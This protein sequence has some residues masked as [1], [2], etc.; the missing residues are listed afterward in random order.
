MRRFL[1]LLLALTMMVGM[2]PANAF[3]QGKSQTHRG[4]LSN[5]AENGEVVRTEKGFVIRPKGF[6]PQRDAKR[7]Y[8]QDDLTKEYVKLDFAE[9]MEEFGT[10][11]S[12]AI[13]TMNAGIGIEYEKSYIF[14]EPPKDGEPPLPENVYPLREKVLLEVP[15]EEFIPIV[16]VQLKDDR[17]MQRALEFA[18]G[19]DTFEV[20]VGTVAHTGIE[21]RWF[22]DEK[23]IPANDLPAKFIAKNDVLTPFVIRNKNV[24]T[25]LRVGTGLQWRGHEVIDYQPVMTDA[26]MEATQF[27]I[28]HE[29]GLALDSNP[30]KGRVP[31]TVNQ[32]TTHKEG[33][34]QGQN[35]KTFLYKIIG[36]GLYGEN[37][38]FREKIN[39][40]FDS[41]G[42]TWKGEE[43]QPQV[44]G[45]S[46]K[47]GDKH[48]NSYDY[49][50]PELQSKLVYNDQWKD[51]PSIKNIVHS[52]D[53]AD[54][55]DP[56]LVEKHKPIYGEHSEVKKLVVPDKDD[57]TPPKAE[58]GQPEKEFKGWALTKDATEPLFKDQATA[59]A[60][61]VPFTKDTTFYA[62]YGP[63]DQGKVAIQYVDKEGNAIDDK[64]KIKGEED[65]YPAFAEGNKGEAVDKTKIPEP[66]FIG[67]KRA[68]TKEGKP[69]EIDVTG[70]TY[71]TEKIQT[72]EVKYEK[73]PD[74]IPEKKNGKDNPDVTPDVKKHYAKLTFQVA[75]ADA[76][77]AKLQLGGNDATSPLVYY[78][79]PLE[80]KSID[81]VAKVK[82][83]SKDDNL[84]K[85][86]AND[87]W[88]YDPD[89][90][91]ST[92]QIISQAMDTD[93][94][95]KKT[96][97]TLTAKVADKIAAKFVDKLDPETIKVW[98]GD[99]IDWKK[100]VKL[101]EANK[102][103]Q[104]ILD[105]ED[106]KVT[107]ENGR[108]SD[109][110]NL[111]N[112]EK[113]NLKVTFSDGS[114]LIVK[115]QMLYVAGEKNDDNK[116]LP[117]DAVK[118]EF[119]IG[120]GVTGTEKTMYV[121]PGTDVKSD[122]PEVSL[123]EG[124]KDFKWYKGN[125]VAKD[126]D[127]KVSSEAIFTA[128][129]G[130][131]DAQKYGNQ[132]EVQDIVKWVG[133]QVEWKD[134]VKPIDGVTFKNVEDLSNRSTTEAGVFTG[135][136]KVTFGDNSTKEIDKQKLIVR[137]KKGE[138]KKPEGDDPGTYP[139]DARNV[140]FVAGE[141]IQALN[142][143]NK[144]MVL[145]KDVALVEADY[146][147]VTVKENYKE[148]AS[149]LDYYDVKPGKL[150]DKNT[151]ITAFTAVK[152]QGSAEVVY[153][154][155]GADI[156]SKVADLKVD[157]QKYPENNKLKGTEDT[158]IDT[159]KIT[160]PELIG[161]EKDGITTEPASDAKYTEAGTAKVIFNYKKIDDII[162][163]EPGKTKPEGY[164][165]VAFKKA[166]GATLDPSEMSYFVNPKADVKAKVSKVGDIY[167][168]SG[169]KADGSDL[170][171]NVPAI[172]STDANKYELK[173][174][175]AD[176]K[177]AYDNFDKVGKDIKA[178]TTFTAQVIKLGEPTVTF[179]NVEIEKGGS[180]VVTPEVRDKY[181]KKIAQPGKPEVK[182]TPDG[183]KVTPNDDGT[184]KIEVPK[185][186]KGNGTFT[187]KVT[188]KVDGKDVPGV[189]NVK[190]QE[191]NPVEPKNYDGYINLEPVGEKKPDHAT[192]IHVLYLYGYQDK[193]VHP[194]GDMTRAEAAAMVARLKNLDMSDT[195]KPDF[196][197]VESKWYNSAINA[198]VKAGLMKGYPDGTFAPNGKIT[199]AEFAQLIKGIDNPNMAELPFTDVAGHWGLDAI[200]QAYANKRIM[201]YPD[202]TFKPNNDITRAEAV[203]ILN[204]LFD[205][206]INEAGLA[207]VRKDIVEFK[208][209]DRSHWAYYQIVEAS[210]TH[211]FYRAKDGEVPEVWV[212]VLKTWNDFLK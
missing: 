190:I 107:D 141:G 33:S 14:Q 138:K 211:E 82:V 167:Q 164:V 117:K 34:I 115:D 205:R 140:K 122:A 7:P 15:K 113:G 194:Q 51:N 118:V 129:A 146:P 168:I 48:F 1:A 209:L 50:Y 8:T 84:Y 13:V 154:A 16:T 56:S 59:E 196:K 96:E 92:G 185:N 110:A 49:L 114:S 21:V 126:A 57:L 108:N 29:T 38:T 184:V 47:I 150:T 186:Y 157:G 145:Q 97:I 134:G 170:K 10:D 74:I 208:D 133:D 172:K 36:D 127:F 75:T 26:V 52:T 166:T 131:T 19:G 191:D 151:T 189:I 160:Q 193:T 206:G 62:I 124:Y 99:T 39:V 197:D 40:N 101:K 88:T 23:D 24:D 31:G 175:D 22:G 27:K 159:N 95:V 85:V 104:K 71:N 86:D 103:L 60:Y 91:T 212:R 179:P 111:P 44:I 72:V 12:Q 153:R 35:G 73:L 41:N 201:G 9:F 156:T 106:T 203:T 3:A 204:S 171:E 55:I 123:K 100:G 132:L 128:N 135:K 64:Y 83:F 69:V 78:V 81:D 180:K 161:Y 173:Y 121:K 109:A 198:V 105:A 2:V 139:E 90:I 25:I 102:E 143:A 5:L 178:D 119:K 6:T 30:Y 183:V 70:K 136:L 53:P 80:G 32:I 93:G 43:P 68:E 144:E 199:R 42:G 202:N 89:T 79:N 176:K 152:G 94:N 162:K 63:K 76:D 58:Q 61:T 125:E 67:Y 66:T 77:K 98:V 155:G 192:D 182:E 120:E 45:H 177:W 165:T 149:K 4:A 112:G 207:N 210:N 11:I 37:I 174:A 46:M 188:Y 195:S 130:Q 142:P 158:A 181:G 20:N 28:L 54:A 147:A 169:K 18:R 163:E 116:N 137:A 200:S 187:I 65:K 17:D 148:K 87:M